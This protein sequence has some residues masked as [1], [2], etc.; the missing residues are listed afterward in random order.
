MKSI[1]LECPDRLHE[2]LE[3]LL[4]SGWIKSPENGVL[5]PL[6][7]FLD[8]RSPELRESQILADVQWVSTG[9]IDIPVSDAALNPSHTE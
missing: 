1:T 9:I 3:K 6:S 5:E 2:H 8:P 4:E 7:R